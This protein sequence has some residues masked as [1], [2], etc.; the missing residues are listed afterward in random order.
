VKKRL[1][2]DRPA[3]GWR[4][5]RAGSALL[6]GA[7][8]LS[9]CMSLKENK[10]VQTSPGKVTIRTVVCASNYAAPKSECAQN[11][12]FATDNHRADANQARTGQI[13]VG[14]RVPAGVTGPASFSTK[15]PV[16]SFTRSETYASELKRLFEPPADQQW[17]GYISAVGDYK[18]T[19]ARLLAMEPEFTLPAAST[20]PFRWRSVVG[21][22]EGADAAAPVSCP[23]PPAPAANRC[24]E[25]PA[26]V[27]IR[28]DEVSAVSDFGLTGATTTA[29]P[30]TTAVVPFKL[31]YVDGGRLGRLPFS[32]SA[33][34]ALPRTNARVAAQTLAAPDASTEVQVQVPVPTGATGRHEVTLRGAIGTPAVVREAT[35][36]INVAPLP[37]QG[38]PPRKAAGKVS[39]TFRKA[40]A[41]GR[42]VIRMVVTGVP[43]KGTV[44]AK[45]RGR[46]CAFKSKTFKGRRTVS[47][48][49]QFRGRTL[50]PVTV[51]MIQIGG[52]NRIAKEI[53]FTIRARQKKVVA[54][55]RCRPPGAKKTLACAA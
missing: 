26:E 15:D 18:P 51:I 1:G 11:N 22:R 55:K 41:G 32:L 25:S 8:A 13:L 43:A 21:F 23:Q 10:V 42:K 3:A 44:G 9:S 50:R 53:R 49:K 16:V 31:R 34:T 40:G 36:T 47:L 52:P 30:G 14:F 19:G 39:F 20:G 45:C 5:G 54:T 17:I 28:T 12:V 46:G 29:F 24:I 7:L 37:Q 48:T 33:N 4:V 35:G 2:R 6:L 27:R 38:P